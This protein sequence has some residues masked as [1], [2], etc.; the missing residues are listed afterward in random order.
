MPS[1]NHGLVQGNMTGELYV[2]YRKTHS[3]PTEL[4]LLFDEKEYVPDICIYPKMQYDSKT[5]EIRV[6]EPPLTAVEI[7]SPRQGS[8]TS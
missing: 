4:T 7:L 8:E 6:T 3:F 1:K 5:D 2:S